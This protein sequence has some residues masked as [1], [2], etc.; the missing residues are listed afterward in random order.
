MPAKEEPAPWW[1][2]RD[3]R[4]AALRR[5]FYPCEDCDLLVYTLAEARP[6]GAFSLWTVSFTYFLN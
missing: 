2:F 3:L 4:S 6:G 1:P 5:D